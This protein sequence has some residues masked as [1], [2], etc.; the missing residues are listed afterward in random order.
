[1]RRVAD[2]HS[3][4]ALPPGLPPGGGDGLTQ[5]SAGPAANPLGVHLN[6]K[7]GLQGSLR[8]TLS[9]E[10]GLSGTLLPRPWRTSEGPVLSTAALAS[11]GSWFEM[12]TLRRSSAKSHVAVETV[13]TP[14]DTGSWPKANSQGATAA[15]PRGDCP[16]MIRNTPHLI[17][18]AGPSA[19]PSPPPPFFSL[20]WG[21][22][23]WL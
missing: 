11:P 16:V 3:T 21:R 22:I 18:P 1:M 4:S 19:P 12:Q 7:S 14:L 15:Q 23:T 9:A 5:A 10:E 20:G 2:S 17:T 13:S 8:H 6:G